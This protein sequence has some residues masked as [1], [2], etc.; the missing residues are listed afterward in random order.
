MS[1]YFTSFVGFFLLFLNT[2]A[3]VK[4]LFDATKAET[5]GSANWVIDA[6]LNNLN[7]RNN[8]MVTTGGTKANAQ[9]VPTPLQSTI[10]T[11]TTDTF[12][13][14]ALSSW[15]ID[16]VKKGYTVASLP[17]NGKIT[18]G[19]TTNTQDLSNYQ[20][21]VI[22]EPN[23]LF[24]AAEK[25]AIIN[26]VSNGG[27]LFI[28][29]DHAG[30]DRNNDGE[31]SPTIWNDLF[32]NNGIKVNPFGI[33]FDTTNPNGGVYPSD[34]SQTSNK[35]LTSANPITRGTFGSVTKIRFS[36][37]TAITL[38][39]TANP[40][41]KGA[42]YATQSSVGSSSGAMVAYG[43]YGKGKIV[44]IGDSSPEDDGTGSAVS[45]LYK[46]YSGDPVVGDNHRTLLMNAIIWLATPSSLPIKFID[47]KATNKA[48]VSTFQWS[49]DERNFTGEYYQLEKSLDGVHFEL[50]G[51]RIRALGRKAVEN[52]HQNLPEII[53]GSV[54]YR[55]AAISTHGGIAYSSVVRVVPFENEQTKCSIFPNPGAAKY[56]GVYSIKGVS[57][58][59]TIIITNISGQEVFQTKA[60]TNNILWNGKSKNGGN[61]VAGIY[62]VSEKSGNS[63][64][65]TIGK[66]IITD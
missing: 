4:I 27:S 65:K 10:T 39:T 20:V 8:G 2:N 16:C 37:G 49:T 1:K 54:Y 43:S 3:Q 42:V 30:A 21:F 55:V 13:T 31:D 60:K 35:V 33:S 7:W 32:N 17:Y 59:S 26:F 23:I 12:W 47:F 48:G 44:A 6:D 28:I 29:A 53:S 22:C 50:I 11:S 52:Y 24:T 9:T 46:N 34:F 64:C 62:M 58:G 18:Y 14:G 5:A 25:T 41:I 15:G 51:A 57:P 63:N 56:N 36:G 19:S 61:L 45:T 66:L 40:T 38:N